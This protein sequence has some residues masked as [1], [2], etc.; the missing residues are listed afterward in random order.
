MGKK[1][2]NLDDSGNVI[3]E[4]GEPDDN[5]PPILKYIAKM[6]AFNANT[7]LFMKTCRLSPQA[8]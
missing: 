3:E 8:A 7:N 1:A 2:Q 6:K 4:E 5:M